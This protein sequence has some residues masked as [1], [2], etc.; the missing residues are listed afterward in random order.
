M[1]IDDLNN[2]F[3]FHPATTTGRQ[4]AHESVREIARTAANQLNDL[5]PEGREKSLVMTH[6]EEAMF[7]ANA[8]I[9]RSRG[10]FAPTTPAEPLIDHPV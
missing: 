8:A 9:A 1:D 2:R 4:L 10:E 6:L 7:W 5:L 3:R